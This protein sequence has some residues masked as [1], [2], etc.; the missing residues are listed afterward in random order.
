MN[1]HPSIQDHLEAHSPEGDLI[2]G[3]RVDEHPELVAPTV[4]WDHVP[5]ASER[6][7]PPLLVIH[8]DKDR[9]VPFSQSVWLVEDLEAKGQDVTFYRLAGADHGGAPFWQP[10][11][12]DVVDDFLRQHLA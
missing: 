4:I 7:L 6:A 11:V 8:G 9:I 12:L 3:V 1:E 2:G 10:E 5:P